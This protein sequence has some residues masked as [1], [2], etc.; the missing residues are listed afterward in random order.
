MRATSETEPRKLHQILATRVLAVWR[1]MPQFSLEGFDFSSSS[2]E[3]SDNAP[4]VK[5]EE[6]F[7]RE[8]LA[9]A[10]AEYRRVLKNW[11]RHEVDYVREFRDQVAVIVIHPG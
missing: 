1:R 9:A 7:R 3:D 4:R 6:D 2:D 5:T 8:D 11:I 10:E